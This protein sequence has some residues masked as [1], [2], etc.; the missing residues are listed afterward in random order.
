MKRSQLTLISL[1]FCSLQAFS[2][3]QIGAYFLPENTGILNSVP[4]GDPIYK[5]RLT[6]ASGGGVSYTY[7]FSSAFAIQTGL[8]YTDVNQKFT[9]KYLVNGTYYEY[10]GKKRLGY[11]D[12]PILLKYSWRLNKRLS[13]TY[14]AGAQ[15]SYLTKGSGA[16]VV[17]KHYAGYDYY[18]LPSSSVKDYNRFLVSG[19]VA[20]GVDYRLDTR[21]TLNFALRAAYSIV[22]N[23]ENTKASYNYEGQ[24]T[25]TPLY[26][27][28]NTNPPKAHDLSIGLQMGVTYD[29]GN[30]S[31]ICPSD[32]WK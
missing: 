20:A 24:G 25:N 19:V 29:I 27:V 1:I 10:D 28:G 21:F 12:L 11:I 5:N 13:Y 31:L 4:S 32:K 16:V 17:Y 7:N 26:Y 3:S 6:F 2:Q 8:Q 23:V 22:N 14:S 30:N 9:S 15:L 18:D